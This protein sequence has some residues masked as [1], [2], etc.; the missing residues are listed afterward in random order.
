MKWFRKDKIGENF[1]N[2]V[3]IFDQK[4]M[5]KNS[6]KRYDF[7]GISKGKIALI[8]PS[9]YLHVLKNN[10]VALGMEEDIDFHISKYGDPWKSCFIFYSANNMNKNQVS[11]MNFV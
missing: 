4:S 2:R 10:L 3:E 5:L 7:D 6:G 9:L 1:N 8:F 11:R